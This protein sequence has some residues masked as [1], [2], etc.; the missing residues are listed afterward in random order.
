MCVCVFVCAVYLEGH[1]IKTMN[2]E[3]FL[4]DPYKIKIIKEKNL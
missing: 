1:I 2:I 3:V 4:P